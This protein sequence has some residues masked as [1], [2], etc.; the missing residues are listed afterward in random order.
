MSNSSVVD[1][2][3]SAGGDEGED[4][5]ATTDEERD[6]SAASEPDRLAVVLRRGTALS[7]LVAVVLTLTLEVS[8]GLWRGDPQW[9]GDQFVTG[10][11]FY[12]DT[13]LVWLLLLFLWSVIGRLWWSIGLL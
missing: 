8:T 5:A 13:I 12:L 9:I 10:V 3:T 7:L 1:P 2:P 6:A 11:G 4:Q